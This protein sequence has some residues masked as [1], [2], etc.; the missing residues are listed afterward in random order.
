[1]SD[2]TPALLLQNTLILTRNMGSAWKVEV[3]SRWVGRYGKLV[4]ATAG[5]FRLMFLM[6]TEIR[7][8]PIPDRRIPTGFALG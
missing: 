4:R 2:L 3:S 7:Q 8:T 6:N 5:I 1:M